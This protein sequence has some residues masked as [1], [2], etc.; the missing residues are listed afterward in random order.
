M[1]YP[2]NEPQL[3]L[4][5]PGYP[6]RSAD[7]SDMVFRTLTPVIYFPVLGFPTWHVW[8]CLYLQKHPSYHLNVAS[9][10]SLGIGNLLLVVSKSILSMVLPCLVVILV[11]SWEKVSLSPS[12]LPS[13]PSLSAQILNDYKIISSSF[14]WR[15]CG[16]PV[17]T[18][19]KWIWLISMRTQVQSLDSLS[20]LR[21]KHC[22]ELWCRWQMWLG[23]CIAV[24]VV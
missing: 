8:N 12:T 1:F 16:V 10:L 2:H 23:S 14:L 7:R 20:G 18:Q 4:A 24:A 15:I 9:S 21:I 19:Q 11:F 17:M 5:F 3:P 13:C 6:P 22:C